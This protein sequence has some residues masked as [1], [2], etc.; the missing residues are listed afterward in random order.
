M[1]G[2]ELR[3]M[4][5]AKVHHKSLQLQGDFVIEGDVTIGRL[6]QM[7]NLVDEPTQRSAAEALSRGVRLDQLVENVNLNFL[8]PLI[9]NNTEL[10]FLNTQD[11][12]NLV[13]LNVGKVQ[14]V[15]ATKTFPQ[16]VEITDGFGEVKWLNGID[17]ERLPN[18][19]LSKSGNQTISSPMQ[20]HGLDVEHLNSSQILLNG[21]GLDEYLQVNKDQKSN[22]TL[23]VDNLDAEE[24]SVEDLHLND[25][26]FGQ[27]LS[28]IYE[29]GSKSL[30]SWHL[31]PNFNG[32]LHAQNLWLSGEIN[33][34]NV[35][36][37]E[38]QLQ[39]LAGNIKYV[40][41]ISF[42]HD[43]NISSL[44]FEN[45]LNG[46]E[47]HRFGRCWLESEGDQNFTARQELASLDSSKGVWLSG[48]LNN[49]TLEALVSRSYRL[50]AS[51][52]LQAVRFGEL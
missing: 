20:L 22:G 36:H 41:D 16:N 49:H 48:Q 25:L 1:M 28:S 27:S 26:L 15:Q 2:A 40:G 19:L 8:Q 47:A 12:Q 31:P 29:H 51:E 32:T 7:R 50:N 23:F 45:S 11:L 17:T 37:L 44:S 52:H 4:S 42:E 9:A 6:L 10:S 21:L 46:I 24:L 33:Q 38:Q 13:Q 39:Q 30:D 43:V 34:V 14:L 3:A 5:P 35:V 18:M